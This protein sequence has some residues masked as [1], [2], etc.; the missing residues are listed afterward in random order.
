ME[1]DGYF[2]KLFIFIEKPS[3]ISKLLKC[4]IF[5]FHS[6]KSPFIFY[7]YEFFFIYKCDKTTTNIHKYKYVWY[8]DFN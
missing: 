4:L 5:I 7:S 6:L 8:K 2:K 1:S 3:I